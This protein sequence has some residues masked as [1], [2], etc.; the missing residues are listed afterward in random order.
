MSEWQDISTA[1][2]DGTDIV[3]CSARL[4]DGAYRIGWVAD[5]YL[6]GDCWVFGSI[7]VDADEYSE[8]THWMPTPAVRAMKDG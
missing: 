8:P 6:D 7:D 3:A 1:P 2:R 5:G 4:V